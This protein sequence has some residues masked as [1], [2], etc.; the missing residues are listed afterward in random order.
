M[1]SRLKQISSQIS[2]KSNREQTIPKFIVMTFIIFFVR[3]CRH[4]GMCK[5]NHSVLFLMTNK[6]L[7]NCYIFEDKKGQI[8]L[9]LTSNMIVT[10]GKIICFARV[11]VVVEKT[12]RFIYLKS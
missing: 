7:S 4:C 5:Q 1:K 2:I 9:I 6:L 11:V 10:F 3:F 8:I 12:V